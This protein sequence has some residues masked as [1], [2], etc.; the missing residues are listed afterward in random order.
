MNMK[1]LAPPD[2]SGDR[3][4]TFSAC[5]LCQSI[6]GHFREIT[7][8]GEHFSGEVA[9][10]CLRCGL[11]FLNPRLSDRA[12]D[13]YY[14]SNAFSQDVRGASTPNAAAI[15]YRD[16][17]AQ[18]RWNFLKEALPASAACLEIGCSSGNFLNILAKNGYTVTGIDPSDGYAA[19]ARNT[20]L[21][22]ISGNFPENLPDGLHYDVIFVFHVLEHVANPLGMLQAIRQHLNTD[23]YFVLEYPDIALAAQR[24]FLPPTYFHKAHL[25][26]FSLVALTALLAQ[27][28]FVV[29]Q[30]FYEIKEMPYDRN[31][32]LVART[33]TP[34]GADEW[35]SAQ[36]N[37]LH[38]A[39]RR[40]L[41]RYHRLRFLR[42]LWRLTRGRTK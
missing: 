1:P 41:A 20:G 2:E 36:A 29:D 3:L 21:N 37:N 8:Q 40:K 13:D 10:I 6:A 4:T 34:H 15:A 26:D 17:R 30:V 22:V 11:V 28:G 33:A 23:G 18:R 9:T 27:A 12:L 39:L 5:P 31:V 42:P 7:A 16:M 25:Y 24:L 14:R 38:N 35:Q 19:Y 32:L